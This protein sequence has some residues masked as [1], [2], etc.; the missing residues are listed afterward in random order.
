[1]RLR[2][3]KLLLWLVCVTHLL[4]G[5]AG[6]SSP[7]LAVRAAHGFYGAT[8]ESTPATVHLIRIIGAYMI[9][10]GLLGGVAARDPE[11]NR[12]VVIA[13]AVLLAI[14]VLQRLLH[15]DEIHTTFAISQARIWG[16]AIYFAAIAGALLY[17]MPK[18]K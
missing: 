11:R 9:A 8:V 18:R 3:L 2:I 16:Q 7:T 12:P 10:M 6:V 4:M 17:L 14:R 1:M 5:I 13:V 15:A